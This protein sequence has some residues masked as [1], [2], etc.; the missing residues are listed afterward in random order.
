MSYAHPEPNQ[1][2]SIA[3]KENIVMN[4]SPMAIDSVNWKYILTP[5]PNSFAEFI[6]QSLSGKMPPRYI[7]V[8]LYSNATAFEGGTLSKH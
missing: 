6:L 5:S 2:R 8:F 4:K 1:E 7:T 3:G